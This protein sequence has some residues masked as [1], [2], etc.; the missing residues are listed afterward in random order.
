MP[1]KK[2]KFPALF[3]LMSGIIV[4]IVFKLFVIDF[5]RVSGTS[6]ESAIRN[7]SIIAVNKLAFGIAL[8]FGDKLLLQWNTPKR[9]DVVIY[10]YDNKIVVKRCIAVSGDRL[11][12]LSDPEYSLLSEGKKVSLSKE[13]Y[14]QMKT[15]TLVPDGY[16]LAVGDN[17]KQSID[18]RTY[19][20]VPVKNILGKILWK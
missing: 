6:M 2:M 20:F 19:G 4:G 3:L 15:N 7:N 10:L 18:S 17:Y 16:I 1:K 9:N 14:E 5:L 12:Y 13:Q 11:E 8:P